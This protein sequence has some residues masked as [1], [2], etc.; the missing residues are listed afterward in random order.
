MLHKFGNI[1]TLRQAD[2]TLVTPE[3]FVRAPL[4]RIRNRHAVG[5]AKPA[6]SSRFNLY[7]AE[8]GADGKIPPCSEQRF[9]YVLE[10]EITVGKQ[11]LMADGYAYLP[12]GA[13]TVISATRNACAVVIEKPYVPLSAPPPEE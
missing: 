7:T 10:G 11:K 12:Q 13:Q 2:H 9:I 6:I 3:T 1:R 8:F 4:P 5:H